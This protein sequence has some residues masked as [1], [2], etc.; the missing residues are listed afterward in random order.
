MPPLSPSA[1]IAIAKRMTKIPMIVSVVVMFV[2]PQ[3][4]VC[5][6]SLIVNRECMKNLCV[7]FTIDKIYVKI[8]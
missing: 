7:A 6:M 3:L 4:D 8:T 1:K 5:F 2:S